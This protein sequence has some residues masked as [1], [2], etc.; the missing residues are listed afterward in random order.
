MEGV[1]SQSDFCATL[2]AKETKNM[3]WIHMNESRVLWLALV[4]MALKYWVTNKTGD[5]LDQ[6]SV[7]KDFEDLLSITNTAIA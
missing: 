1:E 5:F 4:N 3:V 7:N 6:M 2:Y